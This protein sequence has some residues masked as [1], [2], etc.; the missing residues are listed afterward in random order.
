MSPSQWVL[1]VCFW[2]LKNPISDG[3]DI[4]LSWWVLTALDNFISHYILICS[5]YIHILI[6]IDVII[7]TTLWPN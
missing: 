1:L 4:W 6:I 5:S 7:A 2:S 3:F